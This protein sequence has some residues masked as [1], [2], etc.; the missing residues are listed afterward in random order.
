MIIVFL[1]ISGSLSIAAV[2]PKDSI[3]PVTGLMEGFTVF[4]RAFGMSAW[5][6]LLAALA[7]IGAIAQLNTWLIAP[8]KGIYATA[9]HGILP[10]CLQKT[11]VYGVPWVLLIVQAI[12][13]TL[14]SLVFLVM[15]TIGSSFWLLSALALQ[16]YI[17]MYFLMFLAAIRLRYKKPDIHRPY[18]ILGGK[19]GIWIVGLTGFISMIAV[20][21][22]GF[23]PPEQIETGNPIFYEG[24]LITGLLF[25][26]ILPFLWKPSKDKVLKNP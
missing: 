2:I 21:C 19:P 25:F 16:I 14:L 26:G 3:N 18:R 11:N 15:P 1:F 23:L 7:A 9:V 13:V 22:I 12:I 17:V 6:P 24:F 20:F 5:I 10:R 4:F 8:V